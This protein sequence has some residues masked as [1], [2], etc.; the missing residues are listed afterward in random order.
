MK[1]SRDPNAKKPIHIKDII[2]M[3]KQ[4]ESF[5]TVYE[6]CVWETDEEQRQ[7]LN[8]LTEIV[9]LLKN[10]KYET[11]FGDDVTLIDYDPKTTNFT[12]EELKSWNDFFRRNPF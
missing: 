10:K 9:R 2:C 8:R 11:L 3:T 12:P 6:K 7:S 1:L 4:L 5:V